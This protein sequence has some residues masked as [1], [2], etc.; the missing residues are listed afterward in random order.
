MVFWELELHDMTFMRLQGALEIDDNN[1]YF[2][3]FFYDTS[4]HVTD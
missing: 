4:V 3:Y 2:S 1:A